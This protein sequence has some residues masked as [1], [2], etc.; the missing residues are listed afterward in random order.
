MHTVRSERE[1]H[2]A[3]GSRLAGRW[4]KTRSLGGY[5]VQNFAIRWKMVKNPPASNFF[6]P[7][8]IDFD[9]NRNFLIV[10][11]NVWMNFVNVWKRQKVNFLHFERK[12]QK[13]EKMCWWVPSFCPLF[14]S[15]SNQ[16]FFHVWKPSKTSWH[17]EVSIK[18]KADVV[19]G[20]SCLLGRFL[21][22]FPVGGEFQ[23]LA[24]YSKFDASN[25]TFVRLNFRSFY[26][27]TPY[28]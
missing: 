12:T 24:S 28:P 20:K 3:C 8:H 4:S 23:P 21:P 2:A 10:N 22:H 6:S 11:V 9:F 19:G 7:N 14:F 27:Q 1:S 17:Q 26:R 25:V 5:E 15:T 16:P 18:I 13:Q